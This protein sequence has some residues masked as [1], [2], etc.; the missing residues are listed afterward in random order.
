VLD[1]TNGQNAIV[2]ARQ[3]HEAL[4]VTGI[5]LTK[6]DGTA[7]GGVVIGISDELSLPV[8]YVGVGEK[9]ADLRPFDP[10]EFVDALFQ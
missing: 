4:G 2:Q 5:A 10:G 7:K 1:S 8:R 6:L 3:F 9:V